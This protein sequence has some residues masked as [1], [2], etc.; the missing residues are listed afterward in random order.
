V[1]GQLALQAGNAETATAMH[2]EAL[3]VART[4]NQEHLQA[5][6]LDLL[7]LDTMV[8]LDL[9]GAR[10]WFVAAAAIHRR[11]TD[12]EG[13]ANCLHGLAGLAFAQQRPQVAARLLAASWRAREIVG[14]TVWPALQSLAAELDEQLRAALGP[15]AEAAA[16]SWGRSRSLVEAL[17]YAVEAT[18][19]DPSTPAS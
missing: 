4:I 10:T 18:A 17:D 11:L 12:A 2:R 15:D 9:A 14:V 8:Q 5:Q 13:S 6:L 19:V 3:D 16:R 7:G 1:S